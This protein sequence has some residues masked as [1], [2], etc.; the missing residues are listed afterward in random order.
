M[1][2][3][4]VGK[5]LIVEVPVARAE[6][7]AVQSLLVVLDLSSVCLEEIL[8]NLEV[9]V[10]HRLDNAGGIERIADWRTPDVERRVAVGDHKVRQVRG[11]IRGSS[12]TT[13][14]I[15]TRIT[16]QLH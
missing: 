1:S 9:M 4:V 16:G 12:T 5:H 2:A 6:R 8:P 15:T 7:V 14:N 13:T 3:H 11:R 10:I